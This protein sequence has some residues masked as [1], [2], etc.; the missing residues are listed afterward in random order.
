M[1]LTNILLFV[2]ILKL[3]AGGALKT[4]LEEESEELRPHNVSARSGC[5]EWDELP[6]VQNSKFIG[7][8]FVSYISILM[9]DIFRY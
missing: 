6:R 7:I 1:L 8:F 5:P 2:T 9:L 4:L 3:S